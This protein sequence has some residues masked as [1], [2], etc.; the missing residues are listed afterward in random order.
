MSPRPFLPFFALIPFLS[1]ARSAPLDPAA[2]EQRRDHISSLD[3]LTVI[4]GTWS[5]TAA[6]LSQTDPAQVYARAIVPGHQWV[7]CIFKASIRID[8]TSTAPWSGLRLILRA[9]DQAGAFYSIGFYVPA[10]Q[11][12]IEQA[13]GMKFQTL[14]MFNNGAAPFRGQAV[15]PFKLQLGRTYALTV[16]ADHAGIILFVD[17][18]F[19][20]RAKANDFLAHPAG[21]VGFYAAHATGQFSNVSVTPLAIPSSPFHL[22]DK[23]PLNI[24]ARSPTIVRDAGL[25]KMWFDWA[26][27]LGYAQS[28]DG[29]TWTD[30][31]LIPGF[32]HKSVPKGQWGDDGK[33]DAEVLK[34]G[35]KFWIFYPAV[36]STCSALQGGRLRHNWWDG[37]GLAFSDDGLHWS[38]YSHNPTFYTGPTGAWDEFCVGDHTWIKDGNLFKMWFTGI[39]TPE[40]GSVNC[41][42]GY[43]NEFGYAESADGIHWKK[44]SLNPILKQG[45]PGDWDGG[46]IS[47]AAVLKLGDKATASGVYRGLGGCYFLFYTGWPTNREE[48]SSRIGMAYSLDGIHWLK[49]KDPAVTQPSYQHS[50]PVINYTSFG[51]WGSVGYHSCAVVQEGDNVRLWIWGWTPGPAGR[52]ISHLGLATAR[53]SDL[54]E[55]VDKSKKAGLLKTFT[56]D[57]I[58]HVMADAPPPVRPVPTNF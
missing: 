6:A 57:Q 5:H 11:V 26:D 55:L 8:T 27:D 53:V 47:C 16:V 49:Y 13:V 35:S 9:D 22:Y 28:K 43:R 41:E 14:D 15:V 25:Y 46:W 38:H 31:T 40:R 17:G 45:A 33:N 52:R 7:D 23:T 50:D 2:I 20:V 42:L 12:R 10:G 36:S 4:S 56:R 58:D 19:L 39:N 51:Q 1:I 32:G 3:N 18:R 29:I 34:L 37:M 24:D 21:Y 30:R 44:C 48:I 54:L